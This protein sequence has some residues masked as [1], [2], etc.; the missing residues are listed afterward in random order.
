MSRRR[1][2]TRGFTL[3]EVVVT[4]LILGVALTALMAGFLSGLSLVE[5]GRSMATAGADA[6]AVLEEMRRVSGS[7]TASVVGTD[8]AAWSR[9]A[10]LTALQN[11]SVAVQYRNPAADPL[12]ATVTVRWV[13]GTRNR[14]ARFTGLVTKR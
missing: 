5:S 8:W 10:G 9:S 6:R 14:S 3:I 11:E 13:D 2:E 1:G 12:E 7:G 4:T